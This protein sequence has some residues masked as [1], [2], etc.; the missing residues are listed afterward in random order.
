MV[1]GILSSTASNDAYNVNG[2][3]GLGVM[4]NDAGWIGDPGNAL[5]GPESSAFGES[6]DGFS[7]LTQYDTLV[8]YTFLGDCALEGEVTAWDV[9]NVWANFGTHPTLNTWSAG[10]FFYTGGVYGYDTAQ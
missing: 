10:D 5:W 6:W 2:G 8:K 9:N 1:G 3:T 7:N 4:L